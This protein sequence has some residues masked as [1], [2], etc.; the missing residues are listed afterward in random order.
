MEIVQ[1]LKEKIEQE[2]YT[3]GRAIIFWYDPDQQITIEELEDN[4]KSEDVLVHQLTPNNFLK[5]KIEI[6]INNPKKSYLL[7]APFSRPADQEN[8]LLD[9]LL[10]S[11]EFKADQVAILAEQLFIRDHILRPYIEAYPLFFRANDRREKLKK[12][13]PKEADKRHLDMAILAVLTNSPSVDFSHIVKNILVQGLGEELNDSYKKIQQYFSIEVL[14]RLIQQNFG[15]IVDD[16]DKPLQYLMTSLFYQH[17]KRDAL[18]GIE[19]LDEDYKSTLPN[20]CG[21]FIDDWM[22]GQEK[23]TVILEEYIKDMEVSLE[24]RYHLQGTRIRILL[25]VPRAKSSRINIP[26]IMVLPAPGSSAN[27]NLTCGECNILL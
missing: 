8:Y 20:A 19:G 18:V 26:D 1:T 9:I 21:L 15:I 5:L 14:W 24:L 25:T 10:Y 2:K 7:Y 16:K 13:L 3:K 12:V 23:E 22:R 11:T 6:E 17:F 27:K 4:F